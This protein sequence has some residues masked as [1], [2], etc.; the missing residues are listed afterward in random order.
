MEIQASDIS[1]CAFAFCGSLTALYFEGNAPNSNAGHWSALEGDT[2][3][4]VYYLPSAK[5]WSTT[6][7]S[8]PTALWNPQVQPGSVG[9]QSGQFGFTVNWASGMT[10]ALDACTNLANPAWL[11]LEIITLSGGSAYFS[12]PQW[13][14]YPARFYRLRSP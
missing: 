8:R 13:V 7:D 3:A 9:I 12:D 2:N 6:F 5:G 14:N 1:F 4:T 11:P 10:V